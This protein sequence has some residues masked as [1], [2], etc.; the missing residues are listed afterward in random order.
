V[1]DQ[2]GEL[3]M[4]LWRRIH[5]EAAGAWRSVGYDLGRR[6][7]DQPRDSG[8]GD[9]T[10]TGLHTFPGSLVD[11]PSGPVRTDTA[12]PRRFVA[13]TAFC[14]LA[15]LGA[16]GSY[17]VATSIFSAPRGVVQ[18][19]AAPQAPA[20]DPVAAGDP[21][22]AGGSGF[23]TGPSSPAPAKAT[24]SSAKAVAGMGNAG[25]GDPP[26]AV[27]GR[28]AA[29]R[30]VPATSRHPRPATVAPEKT[31]RPA[32]TPCDCE[33]PPVPTPTAP[34][35]T[36]PHSAAPSVTPSGNTD[37]SP[38]PDDSP[39]APASVTPTASGPD[40]DHQHGRRHRD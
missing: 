15:L 11:L 3:L 39:G 5:D 30:A 8:A 9:V 6:S 12:P 10:S 27:T 25:M 22:A 33:T 35:A 19:T 20:G 17:L 38:D 29:D 2:I 21:A 16:G 34:T 32:V 37:S 18:K 13:V 14:L 28:S 23:G 40:P 26:A 4:S 7:P 1:P 36:A 24:P 31:G